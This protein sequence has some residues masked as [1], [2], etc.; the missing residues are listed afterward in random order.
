MSRKLIIVLGVLVILAASYFMMD[1]FSSLKE[2]PE[3]EIPEEVA[4]KVKAIPVAYEPVSYTISS[5]GRL[6]S[7][8][9]VDLIS[10]V[11]GEILSGKIPL[12]KG[13]RFKKGDLLVRIYDEITDYNLKAAKSRFQNSIANIL[14]DFKIDFPEDYQ[15]IRDFFDAL[16]IDKPLPELPVID[17]DQQRIFLASRNILNDY[18][19]IK[20]SEIQLSKHRI[21]APFTGTYTDVMYEVGSIASPGS[22]LAKI[23]NTS[24]LE[25]EVPVP[26]QDVKWINKGDKVVVNSGEDAGEWTG[27]VV[28][29]ADYVDRNSQS[30]SVFISVSNKSDNPLYEGQYLNA[31]FQGEVQGNA[32]EVPRRA[33]FNSDQVFIVINNTLQKAR[34]NIIKVSQQNMI[35]N[36]LDEGTLVVVEPLVNVVEGTVV[37][38]Q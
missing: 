5:T 16:K 20:S 38:V 36:G 26:L 11:Q 21:Y 27:T 15:K 10:E 7:Q 18:F 33:V 25:L 6:G 34:I 24:M 31:S 32:M 35:I 22:R 23:I 37:E 4:R 17:S 9:Y 19:N 8:S 30:V 29:K 1:Y 28:R 3:T 12:K 13:Q 2:T 14:P